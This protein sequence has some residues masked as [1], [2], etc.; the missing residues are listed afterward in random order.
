MT[1]DRQPAEAA[2]RRPAE[3]AINTI[4]PMRTTAPMM[5][6]SQ[7]SDEP[8]PPPAAGELLAWAAGVGAEAVCVADGCAVAVAGT[9]AL[10]EKLADLL[11][12]LMLLLGEKLAIVPPAPLCPHPADRNPTKR[13]A[14]KETRLLV[15]RRM[16]D[17]SARC[18]WRGTA[19]QDIA[20]SI[21]PAEIG[22]L[23]PLWGS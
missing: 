13:I 23:H 18:F 10:G 9:L 15:K 6:H 7:M 14:A 11:G 5:T 17:P 3:R 20:V 21:P 12:T 19:G 16:P 2:D 4:T 1:L 8:D 22:R